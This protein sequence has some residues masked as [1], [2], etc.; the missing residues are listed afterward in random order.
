MLDRGLAV[1]IGA[2]RAFNRYYTRRIGVLRRRFL[3]SD[4]SLTEVRVLYEVAT[5]SRTT[6]AG[7]GRELDLDLGYLSR[8]LSGF[9]RRGFL[10]RLP[11]AAD[12][13]QSFLALTPRGRG[14]FA[15]L[16]RRS[17]DDVAAMLRGLSP[18]QQTRLVAAMRTIETLLEGR[19]PVTVPRSEAAGRH[20][21]RSGRPR[22]RA[23]R[24]RKTAL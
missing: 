4:F 21:G 7:L 19:R 22:P 1:R 23:A 17:H 8:L 16:D 18:A 13:R 10:R 20:V 6:A 14:V 11:S 2:V 12:R 24:T 9:E 3:G 5:R 15:P